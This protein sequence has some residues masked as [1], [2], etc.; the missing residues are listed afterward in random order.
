MDM[1]RIIFLNNLQ[2]FFCVE[3]VKMPKHWLVLW[4]LESINLLLVANHIMQ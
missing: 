3:N 2:I 1:K 4:F